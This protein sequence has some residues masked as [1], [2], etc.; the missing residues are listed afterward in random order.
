MSSVRVHITDPIAITGVSCRLPQAPDTGAFWALLRA[1]RSAI[2]EVPA[3]RWDADEV[4]PDLPEAHRAGLRYGGFLDR[5]DEFDPAFF[6]ISPREAV[7]IDPQQRLFAEL[8]WEAL[9]DAGIVPETLRGTTASVVAGAI[10]GDYAALAQRGGAVTQHSLPGLNRGV[11]ANRV[12][13]ALGLRGPSLVVDSAQSSSLVAVHL[14]LESLRKGET[15]L[16]IVGGVALNF[17]PES[18]EI[19]GRF[20]G[21][22]PDGR[23]FTF[24]ARANG[25]ARGEGG[26]VVV[27]KPLSHAV[28]DGDTVYGVILGSAVNNDGATEGLTVPSAEAQ[29]TVLRQACEDAGVDPAQVRYVELHGTGTPTGDPI[30]AAGVGAVYGSARPADSPVLVGSAKTNVG[31]LE[32]AAGIVGL[33]KTALSIRHREIPASLNYETPNPRID[34][35]ALNLRVRTAHGPWPEAPLVAGVSSFGVGGTNCHVVLAETPEPDADARDAAGSGAETGARSAAERP[36]DIPVVPWLVSGRTGA[37]LR[38]QAGRLAGARA[39]GAGAADVGWSLAG[40]RTHFE[41][42]AV[43]LGP[44]HEAQL[45]AVRAGTEAPGL[46]TGVTGDHGKVALVFPGQGSQWEG[47]ARELLRTSPVF[48]AS[49]EACHEALAPHLDWSLL[50]TLTGEPGAPS[51]ERPDV[52]QPALFAVMVSLVRVWESLGVRPDAVVGHSQGEVAAAYVAGALGLDDAARIVALRSRTLLALAGTGAMVSVPLAA[53]RVA[54]YIAPLGEGLSIAAVNGP[55]TTVVAGS[56]ELVAQLLARC[57]SDG[58]RAKAVPAVDWASH[59]PH[60]EAVREPL[61]ERLA[62]VAPRSCDIAFYS[63]V[64]GSALDTAGLDAEYW[65]ANLRQPVLFEPTL[66]TMAADGYGTFIES[67]PHPVLTFGLREALPEAVVV[68]SLRRDEA[69]WPMLL[70]ALAQLH[71]RGV[72]VEWSAVFAGRTPRRVPLPTYAFQRERYWPEVSA[73]FE[74]GGRAVAARQ[75]AERQET[76]AEAP[77]GSPA[78]RERLAGLPAESRQREALELVRLRTAIVL[79]HLSTD[80]VD[81]NRAFRE[82]GMDSALAVQLR[83]ELNAATGLDLP[84][85]VVYDHPSPSRLAQRLCELAV[86]DGHGDGSASAV[87]VLPAASTGDPIVVVGMACRFPGRA[88]SPE[89]LWRLVDEGTDTISPFPEDRGWDLEGLYDPEPGVRG[90]TY[91]RHGGF[92]DEAAEFDPEF[93][94]ISPREAM[95]MDPQQR[96]LLQIAWETF[97]RVGI[98]PERLRGSDT[99]VF[100]GAMSQEYGPR[101]HEGDDGLGGYLLTGSTVSVA[102]GRVAYTFGLEGPAVTVDTACSSSLVALHQAAQA[103]RGGECSLALAGGVTVMA[104]PG[105]FVEFGQQRGLAADGRCKSFSAAADGVAWAEGAGMV[106]LERLSDAQANGHPILAVIRGSAVNQDGASNGLTAPNGPSQQRVIQAALASAGLTSDRVDAVEA[107]GTGT[108]LG[109]PIEAQALLATYGQNRR[110]DQPLWLGSLKSN[111]G[112]TQAAA[113]IGGVIKMIQAMHHGTLPRTLHVDQ[114]SPHVD[115]NTGNVRLLTEQQP[116]PETDHPRRAAVSSFGI[117]GTNAHLIL[118]APSPQQ[119]QP[120]GPGERDVPEGTVVPWVISARTEQA[121]REQ[122]RQLHTHLAAHPGLTPAGVGYSLATTRALFPHRA[123]LVADDTEQFAQAL[124]ALAQGNP[125]PA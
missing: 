58:I 123:V 12:S 77:A 42:R 16:A 10:A 82:L 113:G 66:R 103:L 63:T 119:Q 38:A 101:L 41:H 3:D 56:S 19:A 94:G 125:S 117:S 116:W 104:T 37:A 81:T 50:D 99:G 30:E 67:S 95:A 110:P 23:C 109:D 32:G 85:S 108:T 118:E 60:V 18:A 100:M 29:A 96:V 124:D 8:A 121:L 34:P 92:L 70:A 17:A 20:G 57:G 43:V 106:L 55:S 5:V 90:K 39:A 15:E 78:W 48:R 22:S 36:A 9:E 102:S 107:H 73:A 45:A 72:P 97:E 46:V 76:H 87:S 52:V 7:A 27:M 112:H 91:T 13:Y 61:L 68:G 93:F 47:M 89:A 51:L 98:D 4:L 33:I 2:T 26:G 80:T 115:W 114:P 40:T 44:D 14:A 84:N 62:G 122:A 35:E 111:I 105:M 53:D 1:G 75:P 74:P 24:D 86:G 54:E 6:G 65:Y 88:D 71:V 120:D 69:A 59:S 49:I 28:R 31:H 21:L 64:T 25:Y 11:I 79:G 83:E